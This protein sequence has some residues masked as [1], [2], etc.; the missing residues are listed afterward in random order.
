MQRSDLVTNRFATLLAASALAAATAT[1]APAFA[2][3]PDISGYLQTRGISYDNFDGDDNLDDSARGS[4][5]RLRLFTTAQPKENLKAVFGIEVDHVWGAFDTDNDINTPTRLDS[6]DGSGKQVGSL[7]ADAKGQIEIKH[8]Y[9]EFNLPEYKSN[10]KFRA[11]V[12]DFYLG[13]GLLIDDDAAGLSVSLNCPLL[14]ENIATLTWIKTNEGEKIHTADDGD[15]YQVQYD[16]KAGG[17]ALAPFV[18]YFNLATE[19]GNSPVS[20]YLGANADG[21]LGVIDLATT[22][23]FNQWD[24]DT[25][26]PFS[27]GNG[28]AASFEAAYKSY[29]NTFKLNLGYAGDEDRPGGEF[30]SVSIWHDVS[31]IIS[32]MTFDDRGTVATSISDGSV[33]N[34]MYARLGYEHTINARTGVRTY[35][36]YAKEGAD[37][38]VEG[39]VFGLPVH[40]AI[41]YGHELDA[42]LD[43]VVLEGLNMTL[44]GGYL[45]ADKDLGLGDD[46]WKL[47]YVLNFKF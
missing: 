1:A 30:F 38:K 41:T 13:R 26:G 21:K 43:Y 36:I 20:Y 5:S 28:L 44:G 29:G 16:M 31:D 10:P 17:W 6:S 33:A 8:A 46:A 15:Y 40:K 22:L 12:Q 18:G 3:T 32:G 9:L 14:P 42:Y 11:G 4:E 37:T 27:D 35:Y 47:G 2:L 34:F 24:N 45:L 23:I 19:T 7:G 39:G 25:T